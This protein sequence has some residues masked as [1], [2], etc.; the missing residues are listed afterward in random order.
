MV[1]ASES[2]DNAASIGRFDQYLRRYQLIAN[3]HLI[4]CTKIKADKTPKFIMTVSQ[5]GD[6][7]K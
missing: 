2:I 4:G 3:G 5:S 6:Y 7:Q 1:Y